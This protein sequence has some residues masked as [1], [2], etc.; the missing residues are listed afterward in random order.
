MATLVGNIIYL[1]VLV[2][3]GALVV[4]GLLHF[5]KVLKNSDE[6]GR[7]LLLFGGVVLGGGLVIWAAND[8]L[9]ERILITTVG[10]WLVQ[11]L[12]EPLGG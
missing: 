7:S 8:F 4:F 10:Q 12:T 5:V 3:S 6:V 11:I 1:G 9:G 2:F